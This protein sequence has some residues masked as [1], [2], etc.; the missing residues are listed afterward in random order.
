VAPQEAGYAYSSE[1]PGSGA[2]PPHLA[3]PI[4][5]GISE[6]MRGLTGVDKIDDRMDAVEDGPRWVK[7]EVATHRDAFRAQLGDIETRGGAMEARVETIGADIPSATENAANVRSSAGATLSRDE[8]AT[9]R[10]MARDTVY[11]LGFAR[12]STTL[13]AEIIN[14][15]SNTWM[16][17]EANFYIPKGE[18]RFRDWFNRQ[19]LLFNNQVTKTT[20]APDFVPDVDH[21]WWQWLHAAR[22]HGLIVGDKMAF[23]A[24]HFRILEAPRI[25]AFFEARFFDAR[26]V[27]TIRDPIQ[28]L[29]STARLFR[30]TDDRRLGG[31][32]AAWLRFI[33]LWA[34]WVRVFPRTTTL[35]ADDLGPGSVAGLGDFLELDLEPATRLLN[36]EQQRRHENPERFDV[37]TRLG[38][39][40]TKIFGLI[41]SSVEGDRTLWQAGQKR[42]VDE[43]DTRYNPS[44][45]IRQAPQAIGL[46]WAIAGEVRERLECELRDG[47]GGTVTGQA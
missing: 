45:L 6:R 13:L 19:H 4:Q 38:D 25:Q 32:I 2:A 11:V 22:S 18:G 12:S 30:I 26:Y 37:L 14:S 36:D 33:Q 10:A 31:E 9:C 16:L 34:D 47:D 3:I 8:I 20:Y 1:Q 27:F 15:A 46:V 23:S 17:G 7:H 24:L 5:R 44:A 35:I 28:T 39:D 42:A 43:I 21:V 29:L 41:R 40:L